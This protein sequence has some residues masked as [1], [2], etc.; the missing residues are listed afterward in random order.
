MA[1]PPV[2]SPS[3]I[4]WQT[5]H[6]Q[7]SRKADIIAAAAVA[8]AVATLC[9]VLRLWARYLQ[10]RRLRLFASDWLAVAAWFFFIGDC[11][12]LCLGTTYGLGGHVIFASNPRLLVLTNIASEH[13]YVPVITLLKF[14]VLSLYRSI[15]TTSRWFTVLTWVMTAFIA[16][17]GAQ[18]IISTDIQ[19]IPLN[20]LWNPTLP[21][22][23]INFGLQALVAYIQNIIIDIVLLTMPIP[24]VR[25]LHLGRKKKLGLSLAFAAGGSTCLVNI[26][27][28]AYIHK[29]SG[30]TDGSWNIVTPGLLSI[31]ECMTGFIATSIATYGPL[32]QKFASK[33]NGSTWEWS[34]KTDQAAS[35]GYSG[36]RGNVTNISAGYGSSGPD[37][38]H[39][40]GILLT[41]DVEL[42]RHRN[43]GGQW[44]R[45]KD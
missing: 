36:N 35:K 3:D 28:L 38:T 39:G 19:C 34:N 26:V 41:D 9:I 14:S 42:V 12:L 40:Q 23:C 43:D 16:E 37:P 32:Y 15:F 22:N 33:R 5:A 11:T 2:P 8:L 4:A 6:A 31:V 1:K 18:I 10:H 13:T 7:D 29:L 21:G 30:T 24:L 25:Q 20:L 17:L 44:V 27:Q 45:I